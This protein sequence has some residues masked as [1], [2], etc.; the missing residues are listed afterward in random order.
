M[1]MMITEE[2]SACMCVCVDG[3]SDV[4]SVKNFDSSSSNNI[5]IRHYRVRSTGTDPG[6][7]YIVRN[8]TFATF[9]ELIEHHRRT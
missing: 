8:H 6:L 7:V 1:M 9:N 5:D 2:R 3:K 4:L